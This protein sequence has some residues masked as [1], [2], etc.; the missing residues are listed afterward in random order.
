MNILKF[1]KFDLLKQIGLTKDNYL[2]YI[3]QYNNN[4][5]SSNNLIY[6]FIKWVNEYDSFVSTTKRIFNTENVLGF[7]MNCAN[8]IIHYNNKKYILTYIR[9]IS[10]IRNASYDEDNIKPINMNIIQHMFNNK[11][12]LNSPENNPGFIFIWNNWAID[13][14][15]FNRNMLCLCLIEDNNDLKLINIESTIVQ[16]KVLI[17]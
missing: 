12:Y 15:R 6:Q 1:E 13:N 11:Y 2:N 16:E 17:Y 14:Y 10:Y 4:E 3:N 8:N 9:N 5:L 7:N